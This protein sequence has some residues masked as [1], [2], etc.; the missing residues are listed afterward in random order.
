MLIW[1]LDFRNLID[2]EPPALFME[3]PNNFLPKILRRN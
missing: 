2:S 3:N 1:N